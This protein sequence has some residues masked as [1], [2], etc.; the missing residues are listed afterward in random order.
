MVVMTMG[1]C[2]LL[3][4]RPE[5]IRTALSAD[6]RTYSRFKH[7]ASAAKHEGATGDPQA[8]QRGDCAR[9]RS[10][11][12]VDGGDV[13]A[14]RAR[15]VGLSTGLRRSG[16]GREAEVRRRVGVGAQHQRVAAERTALHTAE[17]G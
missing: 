14:E 3:S 4:D 16:R 7:L 8:D 1:Q 12:R 5:P 6:L 10:A 13:L 15:C 9:F 11:D 2:M 17:G